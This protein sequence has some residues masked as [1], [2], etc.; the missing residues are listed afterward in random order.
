[1]IFRMLYISTARKDFA[2][3]DLADIMAKAT[4]CNRANKITGL[5]IYDGRRFMQYLEGEENTVRAT[6]ERIERDSRHFAVVVLNRTEAV[7]RQFHDWD[8]AY[9]HSDTGADFDTQVKKVVALTE[10]CD[11]ITMADLVGFTEKRAA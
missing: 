4:K 8:M 7:E 1:M 10:Q 5:L 2:E 11:S 9:R 6:F 3:S